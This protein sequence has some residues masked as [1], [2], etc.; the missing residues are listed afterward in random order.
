MSN[1]AEIVA[2]TQN[3]LQKIIVGLNFCPFAKKEVQRK[4]IRYKVCH[5]DDVPAALQVV[6]DEVFVL[7]KKP[8]IETTL[9]IF[10]HTFA[11]FDQYLDLVDLATTLLEQ[12]GYAGIYQLATF[13]PNYCFADE[14]P[15]D[16]A[17]YTNRSPFPTLH[18][19]RESSIEKVLKTYP[20]PESIPENNMTKA[21]ELTS[22]VMQQLLAGC[23]P[24]NR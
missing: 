7:D 2:A 12:S 17:N 23:H 5:A 21:R 9:V 15:M 8:E 19:L 4:T 24:Q 22:T 13:H 14:D 11:E 10:P 3:W 1:D 20:R 18:L 16:A 6:L